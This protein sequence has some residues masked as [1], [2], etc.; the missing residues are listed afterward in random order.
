MTYQ[1]VSL[2]SADGFAT[3]T[4]RRS[5][6]RNSLSEEHLRELFSAFEAVAEGGARGIILAAEGPVFSSGHDFNDMLGRNL[7]E[8]KSLLGVCGEFMQLIQRI[9]QPVIAQVEGLATAAGCQLVASC[10]LAVAAESARFQTPGG[11]GGW[12]CHTPGVALVRAVGRKRALEMLLTGDAIDARTAADWGLVNRVVP[13]SDV[14]RETR[15][16]LE[17]ATRGS[18]DSK[19][20]GKQAFYAQADL[21]TAGA[22]EYASEVMAF[23]S[24]STDGQESIRSFVEK[25]RPRFVGREGA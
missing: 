14:A 11:H 3:V 16:L 4:M 15:A 13:D 25:R 10:D 18:S 12:F 6:R 9:P 21:D 5:Q 1:H 17:R 23:T 8:M 19:A 22:Y 24:Q 2:E 7:D 20:K